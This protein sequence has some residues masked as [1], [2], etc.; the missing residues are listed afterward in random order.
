MC[1]RFAEFC[2]NRCSFFCVI[3][4]TNKRTSLMEV[5]NYR[6]YTVRPNATVTSTSQ[7]YTRFARTQCWMFD[8]F[9]F[10]SSN[11]AYSLMMYVAQLSACWCVRRFAKHSMLKQ[12]PGT[13]EERRKKLISP[14]DADSGSCM[15]MMMMMMMMSLYRA[16][17]RARYCCTSSVSS[18]VIVS[19]RIRL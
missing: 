10:F 14:K 18:S 9:A 3:S 8:V 19:I 4:L 11:S 15:T 7:L 2:K 12:H 1:H 13:L 17:R 16:Y 6:R 5:S